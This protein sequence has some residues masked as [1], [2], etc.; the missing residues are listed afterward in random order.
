MLKTE[1][2]YELNEEIVEFFQKVEQQFV[3][4]MD[5]NYLYITNNKLKKLIT[6]K[7]LPDDYAV[8][9]NAEILV[10][11]NDK[12]YDK[13]DENIRTIL[14]EQEIDKIIPNLEKGTFNIS[15][16]TLKTST[17]IIKKYSYQQV[18]RANETERLLVVGEKDEQSN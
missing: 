1:Q 2:Y 17:G 14:F 5:L 16:P 3:F 6:I 7:K 9:L 12:M 13:L 11:V 4:A 10:T 18:E 8:L 15:Q